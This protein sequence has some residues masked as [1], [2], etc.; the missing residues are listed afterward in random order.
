M[1][2]SDDTGGG[3]A[4]RV[5]LLFSLQ[6]WGRRCAHYYRLVAVPMPLSSAISGWPSSSSHVLTTGGCGT[7]TVAMS[8][9]PLGIGYDI[10][11]LLEL[12]VHVYT[13]RNP[14]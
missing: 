10:K 6:P 3:F 13:V 1:G 5:P 12:A 14:Q 4:L 2:E 8:R 9:V 11:P 7:R